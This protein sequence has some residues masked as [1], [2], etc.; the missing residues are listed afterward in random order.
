MQYVGYEPLS[1][2]TAAI[3]PDQMIVVELGT[4]SVTLDEVQ[5]TA[6]RMQDGIE[7]PQVSANTNCNPKDL[8]W[9]PS[10]AGD[11]GYDTDA[12]II[13]GHFWWTGWALRAAHSRQYTVS[14]LIQP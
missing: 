9:I 14:A 4:Q 5:V 3:Q 6:D 7:A 12:A 8:E 2:P 13:A 11:D 1:I 10:T